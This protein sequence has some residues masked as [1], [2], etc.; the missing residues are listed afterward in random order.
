M[1]LVW[2][3]CLWGLSWVKLEPSHVAA[4]GFMTELWLA[5]LVLGSWVGV[6]YDRSLGKWECLWDHGQAGL[7]LGH[8]LLLGQQ[9]GL[10]MVNLLPGACMGLSPAGYLGRILPGHWV[11]W[12][13][14]RTASRTMVKKGWSWVTGLLQGLQLGLR[15][16]S[17]LQWTWVWLLPDPLA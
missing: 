10:Q 17:P 3:D 1:S 11:G 12:W 2:W 7:E 8:G 16:M 9:L 4:V 15:L 14:G 6:I 5:D 13:V